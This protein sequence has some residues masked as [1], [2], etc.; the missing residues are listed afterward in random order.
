MQLLELLL[1]L[2]LLLLLWCGGV[3][4]QMCGVLLVLEALLYQCLELLRI[5]VL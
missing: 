3:D 2:L 4:D 1:L 5:G